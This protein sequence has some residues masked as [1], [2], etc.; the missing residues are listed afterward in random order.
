VHWPCVSFSANQNASTQVYEEVCCWPPPAWGEPMTLPL[1]EMG[2]ITAHIPELSTLPLLSSAF[3]PS[4][5]QL[6]AGPSGSGSSPRAAGGHD[7][8]APPA[9]PADPA[10]VATVGDS[11]AAALEEQLVAQGAQ[12]PDAG[13]PAVAAATA[14]GGSTGASEGQPGTQDSEGPELGGQEAAAAGASTAAPDEQLGRMGLQEPAVEV[15]REDD[16][17]LAETDDATGLPLC[18]LPQA[19]GQQELVEGP[20]SEVLARVYAT[21]LACLGHS[22]PVS[23]SVSQYPSV[24]RG[25]LCVQAGRHLGLG[26]LGAAYRA[27]YRPSYVWLSA[28]MLSLST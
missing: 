6:P 13:A 8:P 4:V 19:Y 3:D 10:A 12:E 26:L 9:A 1:G 7:S 14:A 21:C 5:A 28:F 20:F 11:T 25:W 27:S 2:A 23:T 24:L 17:L 15:V 18:L 16:C 22:A